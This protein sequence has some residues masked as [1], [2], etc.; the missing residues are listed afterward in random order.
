MLMIS[1]TEEEAIA[2]VSALRKLCER[3][4]FHLTKWVSNSR[5]VLESIPVEKRAKDLQALSMD[6]ESLPADHALG[7]V[8][9]VESDT[10]GFNI[11][12]KSTVATRRSILSVVSA[13]YDPLGLASP[14]I[15][16]AKILLQELCKREVSWDDEVTGTDLCK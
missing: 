11:N 5:Y 14:F 7:V 9:S 13:V 3:G 6:C 1:S 12:I 10:L 8:W 15:L 4:G 16:P 2:L